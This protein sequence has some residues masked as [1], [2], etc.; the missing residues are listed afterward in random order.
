MKDIQLLSLDLPEQDIE[1]MHTDIVGYKKQLNALL[2]ESRKRA[3]GEKC[4][5]CKNEVN[6]FCNSHS[7]PAFCLRNIATQG[8]V[9]Y[10]N[11]LVEFP[12]M[13]T[14]KGVNRA[15]TFQVIC[16][17]CD[18]KIFSVYENPDNY[19]NVPTPQMLAQIAM[20]NYLKL[21]GKR[22]SEHSIYEMI[23]EMNPFAGTFVEEMHSV[24]ELDFEE[25]KKGFDKAK[26]LSNKNWDGKYYLF[27][28]QKLDYVVPMAFQSQVV[29]VSDLDGEIVNNIYNMS[30]DY[31]TQ[32]LHICV[33]PLENSSVIM[34]FIDS[35]Y[36]RYRSFYKK[37]NKLSLEKRLGI[38][39]YI[40]F[41]Y[42]EEM[43]LSKEIDSDVLNNKNLQDISKQ[44]TIA[45]TINADDKEAIEEAKK[46]Y[47]LS[48]WHTI[49]NLLSAEYKL[50]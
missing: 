3:K 2:G 40:I 43:F 38:I 31:C 10:S 13:D 8:E 49:P 41:L 46:V 11:A 35:K 33:F 34:M 29:L 26:R 16:R 20:K 7:I 39:N 15:G 30:P 5:Y 44:T 18:S 9:Y 25:A 23:G 19:E 45:M 1:L 37:F 48:N 27:Y 6:S 24:Q 4:R 32:D 14:K 50:R 12:L 42:T 17:E 21:I 36:K 47:D 22:V 28:Y